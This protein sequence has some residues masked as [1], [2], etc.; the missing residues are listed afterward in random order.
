MSSTTLN[1]PWSISNLLIPFWQT[2]GI[3]FLRQSVWMVVYAAQIQCRDSRK[4]L[5]NGQRPLYF[6]A[7]AILRCIYTKF[8]HRA[9]TRGKYVTGF[10]NSMINDMDGHIPL[11]LIIFTCTALHHALL[12]WQK[13]TGVHP[14]A[15]KW[16]L[17][18]D[19]SDRSN[20]F[21]SKNES[22]KNASCCAAT[23]RKLVTLA[24]VA[25]TYMFLMNTCNT[26]PESY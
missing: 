14:K 6:I 7:E 26:L 12:E 23:G 15:S 18:V 3:F 19:R 2:I 17:K 21:N 1:P 9:N 24:G 8:Y 20:C 5:A 10:Y 22:G 16:K 4:L 11:P 25:D 13:N